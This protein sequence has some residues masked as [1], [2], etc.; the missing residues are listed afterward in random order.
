[1]LFIGELS[2]MWMLMTIRYFTQGR[3]YASSPD[4][5]AMKARD[6]HREYEGGLTVL[7]AFR[8]LGWYEYMIELS[9]EVDNEQ[10]STTHTGE[11][12]RGSKADT[13]RVD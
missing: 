13:E 2:G 6:K 7:E 10:L 4:E 5:A 1:M 3:V 9:K 12:K 8:Q 11:T